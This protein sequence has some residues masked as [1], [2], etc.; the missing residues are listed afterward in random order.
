[1]NNYG[2]I[3]YPIHTYLTSGPKMPETEHNISLP[4]A[5]ETFNM[6]SS[7]ILC[8]LTMCGMKTILINKIWNFIGGK[9]GE[10]SRTRRKLLELKW[11]KRRIPR[12]PDSAGNV[13]STQDRNYSNTY[14][15]M[16]AMYWKS[17]Y[18][19]L[20]FKIMQIIQLTVK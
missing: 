8:F 10:T 20:K 7:N 18:Y 13:I 15:E 9:A 12:K 14:L 11:G 6:W 2:G 16:Y 3:N 1:M 17:I 19:Q 4:A 5:I